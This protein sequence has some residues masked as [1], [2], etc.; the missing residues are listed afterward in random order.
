MGTMTNF[1]N[2]QILKLLPQPGQDEEFDTKLEEALKAIKTTHAGVNEDD[3]RIAI[4]V[5]LANERGLAIDVA[6]APPIEAEPVGPTEVT[7][8]AIDKALAVAAGEEAFYEPPDVTEFIDL[9]MDLRRRYNEVGAVVAKGPAG[10]GKTTGF[11]HAAQKRGIPV[12]I[13][14][15]GIVTSPEKW[16]GHK[17]IDENGTK[18]TK[19]LFIKRLEGIDEP[20]GL[21]VLD[22]INRVPPSMNNLLMSI[23]DGR[24][25]IH[26]PEIGETIHVHPEVFF[27]ATMN[28]GNGFGGT[29]KLDAALA[30]RLSYII[31]RDFP[32]EDEEVKLAVARTG[33]DAEKAK[34]LVWVANHTREMWRRDEIERP[35]STR[36]LLKWSL[37]V[38]AG[39]PIGKAA[40]FSIL[41]QYRA[42]GGE[43]GDL[44]KVRNAV[45]GKAGA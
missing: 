11:I 44:R 13:W 41:G 38:S 40:E 23:L 18:Y 22:E 25:E 30:E 37:L 6:F 1:S 20:P 7:F 16:L 27:A 26:L 39:M 21:I 14:N 8:E 33:L 34:R 19:S 17:D 3:V 45:Q 36:L 2:E 35:I 29:Y 12:L 9:W 10:C 4:G 15:C 24:Q 43:A 5:M 32:P 42:D 31:P 28:E